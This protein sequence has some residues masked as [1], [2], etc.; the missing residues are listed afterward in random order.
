MRR[1]DT[2]QAARALAFLRMATGAWLFAASAGKMAIYKVGGVLPLPVVAVRWQAEFPTRLA[3]WL[4][5]HPEGIV[6]AI[7]RDALLP[8]GALVAALVAWSQ[9]VAGV[10]LLLGLRTRVAAVLSALVAL[11]LAMS[12]SWH[13]PFATRPYVMLVVLS[14]ALFIGRAGDTLGLDGWRRERQRDRAL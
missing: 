11:A 8:R 3:T 6:A 1:T 7:V 5:Q 12:A 4:S 14:I 2:I 13:D 10:L 9:L